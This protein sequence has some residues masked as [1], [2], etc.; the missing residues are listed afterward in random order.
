MAEGLRTEM[1]RS[2]AMYYSNLGTIYA[3]KGMIDEAEAEFKRALEVHAYDV[4]A[5]FNLGRVQ[6]DRQAT[7]RSNYYGGGWWRS[8]GLI[9]GVVQSRRGRELDNPKCPTTTIDMAIQSVTCVCLE[10][11]RSTWKR[12]SS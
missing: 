12:A 1:N 8:P 4:L 5:L 7:W 11:D 9:D 3:T 2:L 6:A 10:L